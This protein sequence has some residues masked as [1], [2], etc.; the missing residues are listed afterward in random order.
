MSTRN[1][2]DVLR[3]EDE[4]RLLYS[5]EIAAADLQ[6]KI[7]AE[8][9]RRRS[10]AAVEPL[11][12][13]LKS[14]ETGLREAAAEA[15][16]RIGDLS[17]GEDLLQL[18]SDRRQPASIR[19]TSAYALGRLRYRPAIPEL[20]SALA[21]P[22]ASVRICAVAAL[23]AIGDVTARERIQLAWAAEQE[24]KVRNSMRLALRSL[25]KHRIPQELFGGVFLHRIAA[26]VQ[27][28][29]LPRRSFHFTHATIG[30]FLRY[31]HPDLAAAN[32][33]PKRLTQKTQPAGAK[34]LEEIDPSSL[35]EF[36]RHLRRDDQNDQISQSVRQ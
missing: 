5:L 28:N 36:F 16:G 14:E 31:A 7:A 3:A 29:P 6:A 32:V 18:F 13:R 1:L 23:A 34:A 26:Q 10:K 25:F 4:S 2:R 17:A 20:L 15:L 30:G 19:D 24:P 12:H 35:I 11:R 27:E 22:S 21:D 8:L 33:I 9:G